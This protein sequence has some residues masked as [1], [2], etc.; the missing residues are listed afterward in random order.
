MVNLRTESLRCA[1]CNRELAPPTQQ[2]EELFICAVC[3][4][5]FCQRCRQA[6]KDY[7]SCPVARLQGV[8][9]HKLK[10]LK[11]LP[12]EFPLPSQTTSTA[13][14]KILPEKTV[15]ILEEEVEGGSLEEQPVKRAVRKQE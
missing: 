4:A 7:P 14:V 15:K 12:P 5:Y 1:L 9:E 10:L 13:R 11:L 8:D 6:I 3:Q 2:Q